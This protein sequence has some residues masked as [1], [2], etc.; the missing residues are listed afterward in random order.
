MKQSDM[1]L[2]EFKVLPGIHWALLLTGC[3]G[4]SPVAEA[5]DN[6]DLNGDGVP[7]ITYELEGSEYYELID[8]NFDSRVD[9]SHKYGRDDIISSSKVDTD[10]NGI[11]ETNIYYA[12]GSIVKTTTDSDNDGLVDIVSVFEFGEILYSERYY[13]GSGGAPAKIGRVD[14]SFGYPIRIQGSRL[15]IRRTLHGVAGNFP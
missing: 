1:H 12:D 9:E 6:L 10:Y 3:A 8:R 7:D 13:E 4:C 14:Y 11:L 2:S 5:P 15:R